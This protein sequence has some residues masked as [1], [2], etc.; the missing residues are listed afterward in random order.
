MQHQGNVQIL[1]DLHYCRLY[2]MFHLDNEKKIDNIVWI[3]LVRWV[4]KNTNQNQ[5]SIS[6]LQLLNLSKT[7]HL[8]SVSERFHHRA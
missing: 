7:L 1:C 2:G 3:L 8:F 6:D 4:I 5:N